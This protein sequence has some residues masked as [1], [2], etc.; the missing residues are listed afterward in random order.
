MQGEGRLVA[1]TKQLMLGEA[2]PPL[3]LILTDSHG[4]RVEQLSEGLSNVE[5]AVLS[6]EAPSPGRT[7][8]QDIQVVSGL[9]RPCTTCCSE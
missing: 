9:V 5:V 4:N 7:Y 3:L 8:H 1:A 6:A 2:L